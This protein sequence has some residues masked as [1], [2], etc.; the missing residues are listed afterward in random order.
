MSVVIAAR[1]EEESLPELIDDLINQEY[2]L[3]KFEIIIVN[4]RSSDFT[5]EILKQASDNYAFIKT[6]TINQKSKLM[7]SKKNAINEGI[8]ISKE[9]FSQEKIKLENGDIL[10]VKNWPLYCIEG[11]VKKYF[12]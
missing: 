9:W 4:D 8:K 2:P 12:G 3:N 1:N 7:T 6:I 11:F 10:T 5:S